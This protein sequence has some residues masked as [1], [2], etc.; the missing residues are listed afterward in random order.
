[1]NIIFKKRY[2]TNRR[3]YWVWYI[4][5]TIDAW[6]PS[7]KYRHPDHCLAVIEKQIAV[8]PASHRKCDKP[9]EG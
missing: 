5:G 9:K 3:V 1:M 6:M 8:Q 7:E 2:S 4:D